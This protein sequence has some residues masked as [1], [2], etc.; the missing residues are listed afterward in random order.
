MKG[1][2]TV[3]IAGVLLVVFIVCMFVLLFGG[4]RPFDAAPVSQTTYRSETIPNP[5]PNT[6][7]KPERLSE[8]GGVQGSESGLFQGWYHTGNCIYIEQD[9]GCD[10]DG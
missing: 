6:L 2:L 9:T 10:I 8:P 5:T 7:S 3:M 4:L 1:V